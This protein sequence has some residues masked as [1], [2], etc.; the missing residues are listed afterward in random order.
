VGTAGSVPP[1]PP[2]TA[3]P[4]TKSCGSKCPH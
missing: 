4:T 3:P 2:V 1:P